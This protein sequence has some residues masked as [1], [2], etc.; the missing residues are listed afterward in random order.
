MRNLGCFRPIDIKNKT[1]NKVFPIF[2][3]KIF[4]NSNK[5]LLLM[6]IVKEMSSNYSKNFEVNIFNKIKII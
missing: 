2:Y 3:A 4:V 1:Q 5:L 6:V